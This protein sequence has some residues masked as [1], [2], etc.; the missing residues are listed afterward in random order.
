MLIGSSFLLCS[1]IT[2]HT[3]SYSNDLRGKVYTQTYH[4]HHHLLDGLLE[5]L[6]VETIS[7]H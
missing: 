4:F 1:K 7:D 5:G 2:Y 3:I 6:R